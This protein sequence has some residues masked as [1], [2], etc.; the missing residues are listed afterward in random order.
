MKKRGARKVFIYYHFISAEREN[1]FAFHVPYQALLY[2][3]DYILMECG[4]NCQ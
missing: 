1:Q 3:P 4:Q 2:L